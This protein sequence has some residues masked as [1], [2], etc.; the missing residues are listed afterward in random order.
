MALGSER[1][2]GAQVW[3]QDDLKRDAMS[4]T[5]TLLDLY[6]KVCSSM[7]HSLHN[8]K[9]LLNY[10]CKIR[11]LAGTSQAYLRKFVSTKNLLLRLTLA[12]PAVRFLVFNSL[13][14]QYSVP[15]CTLYLP[16]TPQVSTTNVKKLASLYTYFGIFLILSHH[17]TDVLNVTSDY[18]YTPVSTANQ[19]PVKI[20]CI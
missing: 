8:S 7:V 20:T 12:L 2:S 13:M 16:V 5:E 1:N 15:F 4:E 14:N 18:R 17:C 11:L 10:T 6:W 9:F 3:R 19:W